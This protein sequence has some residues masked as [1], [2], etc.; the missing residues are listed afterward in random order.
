MSL[1]DLLDR[2]RQAH[3]SNQPELLAELTRQFIGLAAPR[4]TQLAH[5]LIRKYAPDFAGQTDAVFSESYRRLVASLQKSLPPADPEEY[6]HIASVQIRFALKDLIRDKL[7]S[8]RR[9][10]EIPSDVPA[11]S[12][13]PPDKAIR[14]ELWE[15]LF[16]AIESL[17]LDLANYFDLHWTQ[18]LS[19]SECARM[20]GITEKQAR[21]LWEKVKLILGRRL[22][23]S[24]QRA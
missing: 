9:A 17:P 10:G 12:T 5:Q 2:I 15:Q 1:R 16:D 11:G 22:G 3:A 8:Q 19:H 20:L 21:T 14:S 6:F 4:L 7:N 23:D 13:A 18:G 24:D